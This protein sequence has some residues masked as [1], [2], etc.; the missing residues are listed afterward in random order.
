MLWVKSI[1]CALT[2]SFQIMPATADTL[3]YPRG[4]L[5]QDLTGGIEWMRCTVGQVWDPT[6]ETCTGDAVKLNHDEILQAIDQAN[7]KLGDGWRLPNRSELEGLVCSSCP[8]PK[9]NATLFP[10]TQSEPY[11]TSQRNFWSPKNYWSVNFMTGDTYGRF[12]P[13]QRLMVRLV[14]DRSIA[15]QN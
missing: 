5:V 8:P 10:R 4:L 7:D 1:A 11:W 14:R 9:I 13:Q 12:F 6:I 15:E 3:Y 2:L